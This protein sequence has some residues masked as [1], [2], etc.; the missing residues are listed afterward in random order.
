MCTPYNKYSNRCCCCSCVCCCLCC[1]SFFLM[2]Y[3]VPRRV[4]QLNKFHAAYLLGGKFTA[5]RLLHPAAHTLPFLSS[6]RLTQEL[7]T[8]RV[9]TPKQAKAKSIFQLTTLPGHC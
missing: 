1:S 8:A 3:A 9:A 4:A 2:N 5:L 7:T 6:P